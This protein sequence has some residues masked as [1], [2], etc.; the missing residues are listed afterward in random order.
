M[1]TPWLYSTSD[2][3]GSVRKVAR[4]F[5]AHKATADMQQVYVNYYTLSDLR[6]ASRGCRSRLLSLPRVPH[7]RSAD[8]PSFRRSR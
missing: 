1:H 7:A 6:L 2:G 3:V 8:P 5:D 4:V